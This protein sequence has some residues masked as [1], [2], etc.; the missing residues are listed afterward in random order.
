M[1]AAGLLLALDDHLDVDRQAVMGR[2]PCVDRGDVDQDPRLVVGGATAEQ[3]AVT[4]G[5]L[6]RWGGPPRQIARRLDV[7][8]RVAQ[9]RR[10]I[11]SGTEPVGVHGGMSTVDLEEPGVVAATHGQQVA[12]HLGTAAHLLLVESLRA[13]AG[14]RDQPLEIDAVGRHTV[15]QR[16]ADLLVHHLCEPLDVRSDMVVRIII[17]E[18]DASARR[19]MARIF[20]GSDKSGGSTRAGMARLTLTSV[21]TTITFPSPVPEARMSE[22][23]RLAAL[24][25]PVAPLPTTGGDPAASGSPASEPASMAGTCADTLGLVVAP[26]T[27]RFEPAAT[28]G[29]IRAGQLL[30]HITGGPGGGGEGGAPFGARMKDLLVRPRQLVRRGQ[31]LAWLEVSS[32]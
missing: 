12:H 25:P 29:R 14:N 21:S 26:T 16:V 31:A 18:A 10:P 15:D 23:G 6:E 17:A 20:A 28:N 32:A 7:V 11:G 5:R 22:P 19:V 1:L 4:L 13:H 30:G 9:H 3:P 27:G 8:V 2:Q 24:D